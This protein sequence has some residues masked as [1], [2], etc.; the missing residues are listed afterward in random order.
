MGRRVDLHNKL[1][2]ICQHVYYQPPESIKLSFP[3]I[4]YKLEDM[5]TIWANNLPYSLE[6]CYQAAVIDRSPDS[7][8]REALM[9]FPKTKFIRAFS[10]DNLH[11][12]VFRIYD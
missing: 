11:H 10:A 7:S 8:V 3:C 12:Y 5:P 1:L 9:A 2:S 6:H 4:V